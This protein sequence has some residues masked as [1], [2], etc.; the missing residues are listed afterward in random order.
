MIE[1][2]KKPRRGIPHCGNCGKPGHRKTS[3][4]HPQWAKPSGTNKPSSS[5][6]GCGRHEAA[7]TVDMTVDEMIDCFSM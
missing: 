5:V 1:A 7:E 6:L 3:C 2:K 4:P